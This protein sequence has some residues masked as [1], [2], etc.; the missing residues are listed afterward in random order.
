MQNKTPTAD[1]QAFLPVMDS[2]RR[3]VRGLWVRNGRFYLQMRLPN[4]MG[5][6]RPRKLPLKASNLEECRLEIAKKLVARE[7]GEILP[8]PVARPTLAICCDRYLSFYDGLVDAGKRASTVRRERGNLSNVRR[9]LG[10]VRVTSSPR[11][12]SWDSW[13]SA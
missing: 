9:Y 6:V 11:R 12:W 5:I 4:A 13:S 2:R 8:A 1:R 7:Q 10:A 3:R